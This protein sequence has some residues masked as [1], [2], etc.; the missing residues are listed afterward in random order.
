MKNLFSA[1]A[2]MAIGSI[3]TF[4]LFNLPHEG[5]SKQEWRGWEG[6]MQSVYTECRGHT[7]RIEFEKNP[8]E[9][10]GTFYNGPYGYYFSCADGEQAWNVGGPDD[11]TYTGTIMIP[12]DPRKDAHGI[13]S[14]QDPEG[15][16]YISASPHPVKTWTPLCN[17]ENAG[18]S[19]SIP[20]F[21]DKK[22]WVIR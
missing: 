19:W 14:L 11:S 15:E 10:V 20:C 2:F 18:G 8:P 3:L 4:G 16:C 12:C 9:V 21:Y 5:M 7:A 6:F 22:Y 1:V 13:I 17:Q